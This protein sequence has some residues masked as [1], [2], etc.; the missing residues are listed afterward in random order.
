MPFATVSKIKIRTFIGAL[1]LRKK[2][3]Q[4]F[5]LFCIIYHFRLTWTAAQEAC[6]RYPNADMMSVHNFPEKS[7]LNSLAANNNV[8]G[9]VSAV[10]TGLYRKDFVT[11]IIKLGSVTNLCKYVI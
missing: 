5:A 8:A 9:T 2:K 3:L 6:R 10:W 1:K 4:M 7:L 11:H